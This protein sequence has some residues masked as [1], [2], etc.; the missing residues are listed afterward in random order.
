MTSHVSNHHGTCQRRPYS[1]SGSSRCSGS[2][3]TWPAALGSHVT[4]HMANHLTMPTNRARRPRRR[5]PPLAS[6]G[7]SR[8]LLSEPVSP[9]WVELMWLKSGQDPLLEDSR[10]HQ[11]LLEC[12]QRLLR[13][14]LRFHPSLHRCRQAP[15]S[16]TLHRLLHRSQ[17]NPSWVKMA[18]RGQ[19]HWIGSSSM[20]PPM[21]IQ[22]LLTEKG[23]D[24]PEVL[25][26]VPQCLLEEWLT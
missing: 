25:Q 17:P 23:V 6:R 7:T 3:N 9:V 21:A 19:R 16:S 10:E 13:R 24:L 20:S 26:E 14:R 18:E 1:P 11:R 4:S 5:R 12:P 15:L 2:T 22:A 8:R